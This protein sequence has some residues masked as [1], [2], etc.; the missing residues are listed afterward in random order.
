MRTVRKCYLTSEVAEHFIEVLKST[1]AVILPA[2]CDFIVNDFNSKMKEALD[3][4]APLLIKT[5]KIK[6][7]PLWRNANNIKK[8]KRNCKSAER[9][10]RKTKLTVHYEILREQLQTYNNTV[11]Q[12]RRTHFSKLITDHKNNPRFIFSTFDLLTSNNFYKSPKEASDALCLDFSDHFRSKI[13]DI[14]SSLLPQQNVVFSTSSFLPEETLE[15]FALVDA[16][17]LGRVFSQVNPTTCLLDP[18]PTSLFKR[19]Y[20]F[21][22][23][24]LLNMVN[25]SLQTGVFP[26]AFKT[27][28][29]KP[30]LKKSNLD[31]NIL[32]NYRPVSNLPFL[33]K[34]LEK[35]V[36]NQLNYFLNRNNILEKYQSG[37]RMNHSTETALLKIVNDT[38]CNLDSQKLVQGIER[39]NN[40]LT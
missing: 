24:Q 35:L 5:A 36:F 9:R 34:V 1:P 17:T 28:V 4:V 10:W 3:S 12:A 6:P 25:C 27:A 20:G 7:I 33:S 32:N 29:V 8:L 30:L 16:R 39:C 14:R 21:F 37:F 15:S 2:P 11:K 19:F 31:P 26:A 38:R 18:I 13:D 40:V 23:E 22:E